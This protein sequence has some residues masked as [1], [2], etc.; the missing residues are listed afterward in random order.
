MNLTCN[1]RREFLFLLLDGSITFKAGSSLCSSLLHKIIRQSPCFHIYTDLVV[2]G[3]TTMTG[4][5]LKVLARFFR[6]I[7]CIL[8]MI[9]SW[10]P[11]LR[12]LFTSTQTNTPPGNASLLKLCKVRTKGDGEISNHTYSIIPLF[13]P[14]NQITLQHIQT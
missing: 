2:C 10:R 1:P 3:S 11:Q 7:F 8:V 5:E 13:I 14:L 9:Q 12:R 6:D 4:T